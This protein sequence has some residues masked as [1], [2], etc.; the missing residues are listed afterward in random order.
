GCYDASF[1]SGTVVS[2]N[3]LS[4]ANGSDI[5]ISKFNSTGS[6][7]LGS[8]YIGGS[9]NDGLNLDATLNLNYGDESRGEVVV[10]S[11]GNI[12]VCSST[13][14]SAFPTTAGAYSTTLSGLQEG[15][16]FKMD[17]DLTA[18]MW[19]TY[20]GGTAADGAYSIKPG[21]NGRTYVTG[22]TRSTNFPVTAG[23]LTTVAPGG[24]VDAF[25]VALDAN[26]GAGV[27]S[28]YLGTSS[29]DQ[30]YLLDLN[31]ASEVFVVGQTKGAYPV[32]AGVY[33][34]ANGRHFIHK[35][36]EDLTAT[37]FS[38]VFGSGAS[39]INIS[40]TALLVDNCQ[41]IYVS[42][43]GGT[44]NAEGTTTG[45]PVTP[46]AYDA[47][48]DG[49]DFY[50]I[51][52]EKNAA[53]LLYGSFFGAGTLAEHVDGGTSRFDKAGTIY[54]AVCAG[55]GSSDA[56][57]TTPGVWSNVNG[58]TNCN[59]GAIK[60]EFVYSGIT[61]V[62]DA[63]PNV[64]ACD[65]PY[66][67]N[68]TGSAGA[69]DHIWDFGDGSTSTLAN[70]IH[71]F[72]DTGSFVITYIAIDSATCN[73]ADTAQ[74][75][76]VI[77]EPEVF[78]ASIVVPPY[79]PCTGDPLTIQLDFTGTGADY[80]SWDMGDG[81]VYT[82]DTSIIHTY[83]APGTYIVEMYA[84]DSTCAL[85]GTITDTINYATNVLTVNADASPNVFT[86]DPPYTVTFS[87]GGS[88]AAQHFWDFDNGSTS[89]LA[90]PAY[91]FTDTGTYVIMY[92]ATD[93]STCNIS[94]TSYVTVQ[95]LQPEVF[96]A[97][98]DIPP[99]DP[100][101]PGPLTIDLNFT[102]T[103]ADY[104]SWD[105]GEGTVYTN[106]FSVTHTYTVPGI[107]VI[108]MYAY[109]SACGVSGTVTDTVE[110][111]PT[112]LTI[113][114]DASPDVFSCEP[115]YTVTFD[116]GGNTAPQHYWNFGD[117]IGS[118]ALPNPTYTFT[119]TGVFSVMYVATDSSTCN[120]SDTAYASVTILEPE[121]FAAEFTFAPPPPCTDTMYVHL[122]FTGTGA[123]SLIWNMG[124][125]TSFTDALI[126][127]HYYI[128]PGLYTVTLTAYDFTCNKVETITS[129]FEKGESV[130]GAELLIPNVFSPNGDGVNDEF[131]I[132]YKGVS[133]TA[134]LE[135][136]EVYSFKIFNRWGQLIFDNQGTA[137]SW[138]GKKDGKYVNDGVYFYLLQYKRTCVDD[139]IIETHGH[140]TVTH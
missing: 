134:T 73:I 70:P 2:V 78:N 133:K 57:P 33:S 61:A 5:F 10:D 111:L 20:L 79:D 102:G 25:V 19:S 82:G 44:V 107:Y 113:T 51:V 139:N 99:Y 95:I 128:T 13:L 75:S 76:V 117:G 116:N 65:P 32:S 136:M 80:L 45:L 118:S 83:T 69:A 97:T 59:L 38:T 42:G 74:L 53:S 101:D 22:G 56:F 137:T 34:N 23:A 30:G 15:C 114:A 66:D 7:L 126:V 47:V 110:Y 109:D 46:D 106:D 120:I 123:D 131:Y 98:I 8:T 17:A 16:A 130:L 91:T 29:Y 89:T 129:T 18:L 125:G 35:L 24:T 100:C 26:T 121:N 93:S 85:S 60:M 140:I 112:F 43:W 68:F 132:G 40:P 52:L 94:D 1:N 124:D 67:V 36:N 9:A 119:T 49:S 115:P 41:N 21:L 127:D 103:G 105:M 27:A 50:F 39:T 63:S 92:I 11:L 72:T 55:C 58:S 37:V 12:Y 62:A 96:A 138:D 84:Y 122:L 6:A 87:N 90:N 54:Q 48:T 108:E 88:T 81:T 135:D 4:Y 64:I 14:S 77:L 31:A 3:S 71:T 86:C 104:I 28:T